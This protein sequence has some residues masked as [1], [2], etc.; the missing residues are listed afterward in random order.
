[1]SVETNWTSSA[2]RAWRSNLIR[3]PA[4]LLQLPK[5]PNFRKCYP[6]S[7]TRTTPNR[8]LTSHA[9]NALLNL[10]PRLFQGPRLHFPRT[11]FAIP[12]LHTLLSFQTLGSSPFFL[13]EPL[14][15]PSELAPPSGSR[16][17]CQMYEPIQVGW[18][19]VEGEA[20]RREGFEAEE[21]RAPLLAASA[22]LQLW[23]VCVRGCVQWWFRHRI[24][25]SP[26]P[27]GMLI[28]CVFWIS[29]LTIPASGSEI[30][31]Y[32]APRKGL[33][34]HLLTVYDNR[35]VIG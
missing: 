24:W 1:M 23:P 28:F 6:T 2:A 29:L 35:I 7:A 27:N 8:I 3:L 5:T 22:H 26:W 34:L 20:A 13:E 19:C 17:R 12:I 21:C 14:H 4:P 16:L 30:E 25:V 32:L 15:G 31:L 33:E 11:H 18:S 9:S 10:L